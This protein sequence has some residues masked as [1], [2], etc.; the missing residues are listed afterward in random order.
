MGWEITNPAD[1]YWFLKES[2]SILVANALFP[3]SPGHMIHELDNV[4]RHRYVGKLPQ[5]RTIIAVFP[6]MDIPVAIKTGFAKLWAKENI[7][8]F[9][10]NQ[11]YPIALEVSVVAPELTFDTGIAHT[12]LSLR[13]HSRTRCSMFAGRLSYMLT[14]YDVYKINANLM[15]LRNATMDWKPWVENHD[16]ALD[17]GDLVGD[18]DQ[19]RIA[20]LHYRP[21]DQ[22]V[23]NAAAPV[24]LEP[25][26]RA[27][28]HLRD[29]GFTVVKAGI[30]PM[31]PEFARYGVINYSESG[32]RCFMNDMRLFMKAKFAMIH[33]SGLEAVPDV[34]DVPYVKYGQWGLPLLS[35]GPRCVCQP[36]IMRRKGDGA[37]LNFVEQG[38]VFKGRPEAWTQ[39]TG[40]F[41]PWNIPADEYDVRPIEGD[42]LIAAVQECLA[43][44]PY[45]PKTPLQ[46][47]FDALDPESGLS[48]RGARMSDYFLRKFEHL[49]PPPGTRPSYYKPTLGWV[50]GVP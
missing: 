22:F 21:S 45:Q 26:L 46:R 43:N 29:E 17:L 9:T 30:E 40:H 25:L 50:D 7:R 2:N 6:E 5:D 10:G 18:A 20:V 39:R 31:P 32:K 8:I 42:E 13:D 27:V 1:F 38:A 33:G 36:V 47:A 3:W 49:F 11:F 24:P 23:G 35:L 12:K 28:A 4:L 19:D 14:N 34:F 15:Q 37:L 41:N 16:L 48:E 44:G